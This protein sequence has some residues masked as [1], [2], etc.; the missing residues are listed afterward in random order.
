MHVTFVTG[1]TQ[2]DVQPM[3]ALAV[4]L[5]NAGEQVRF[6]AHP[7]FEAFVQRSGVPFFPLSAN[8][9]R[10]VQRY[11]HSRS[12]K[13]RF[14]TLIHILR[15]HTEPGE[16]ELGRL[17][18]ACQ[19]TDAVVFP[20]IA[21]SVYHIAERLAL[22]CCMTWL[23]PQ[24]PT[25]FLPSPLGPPP[26]PLG[27]A[28]NLFTH[29]LMQLLFWLPTRSW[30][31]RW[32]TK[33]LGLAPISRLGPLRLMRKR[34]VPM[35]F[36][37]SPELVSRPLDW[38]E[39]LHVTGFW[40]LEPSGD[41]SPPEGLQHFID[42]GPPPLS[43]GFGSVI[44][45]AAE[46]L[47]RS[48]LEA[49]SATGQRAVLVSGWNNYTGPLPNNVFAV[50]SVPYDWLFPRVSAAIHAAGAGTVAEALRA[51]IPSICVPFAGEQK[52]YAKKLEDLGV[53][54]SPIDRRQVTTES[55]VAAI[56]QV[57]QDQTM[58]DRAKSFGGTIARENGVREAVRL[59]R[60]YLDRSPQRSS[61][62]A[63]LITNSY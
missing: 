19:S 12:R 20:P 14:A 55:L 45:T 34:R 1:G 59:L 35:L 62:D 61:T 5:Q 2:G 29:L 60:L 11:E 37:F 9:P 53:A 44:D 13:S 15:R 47:L 46:E 22:P 51:G 17:W 43:I 28:Y 54:T 49:L 40:F 16:Q 50:K 41:W 8:D 30:V 36:G 38:P 24:Y 32:R 31:N 6:C 63:E 33:T 48:I 27:Q 25:R 52:F 10:D 4:G 58:R 26:L 18:D 56:N 3:L 21:G 57:T 42:A 39:W 7:V 23:H